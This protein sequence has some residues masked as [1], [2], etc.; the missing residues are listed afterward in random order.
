MAKELMEI[1]GFITSGA[2]IVNH[3]N[4]LSGNGTVDSPL[5]VVPGYNETVLY[6][7][8]NPTAVTS[9]TSVNLSESYLNFRELKLYLQASFGST[10]NMSYVVT[11]FVSQ[12]G[13]T[14]IGSMAMPNTQ[15]MVMCDS[16]CY[17]FYSTEPLIC[18]IKANGARVNMAVGSTN[19]TN[20]RGTKL[21]K[22]IG[23]NRIANN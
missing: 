9:N 12:D 7:A 22:V 13:I 20:N 16:N 19:V 21:Y 6:S 3:D 14:E 11:T 18:Y 4:S 8:T 1:G 15:S 17:V 10:G 23:V 2:E 5:R